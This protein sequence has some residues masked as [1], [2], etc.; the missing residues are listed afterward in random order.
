MTQYKHIVSAGCSFIHGSELGDEVP[1]SRHT[2]PALI[3]NEYKTTYETYVSPAL[4]IHENDCRFR[5]GR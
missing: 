2:Y 3:A 4:E 1:F 5:T